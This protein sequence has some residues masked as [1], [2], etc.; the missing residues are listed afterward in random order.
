MPSNYKTVE[1]IL[2][3]LQFA[4]II[5]LSVDLFRLRHR[6]VSPFQQIQIGRNP[7]GD[8]R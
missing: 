7:H 6:L 5:M 3:L 1:A 4:S 2:S 8:C